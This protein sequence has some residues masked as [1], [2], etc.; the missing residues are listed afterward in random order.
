MTSQTVY[1]GV[2]DDVVSA[3][4]Q[5]LTLKAQGAAAL[6]L[7][8][9]TSGT[10]TINLRN[11]S[12]STVG[13]LEPQSNL[14]MTHTVAAAGSFM[15]LQG[16]GGWVRIGAKT[17]LGG[18]APVLAVS[19]ALTTDLIYFW[20]DGSLSVE[21]AVTSLASGDCDANGEVGRIWKYTKNTNGDINLCACAKQA[22]A[23]AFKALTAGGDCT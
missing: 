22:G 20:G 1:S 2:T 10:S 11:V 16:S 3:S 9:G 15:Q 8:G 19:E 21:T 13:T 23:F 6:E 17:N 12:G 14:T 4:G 18:T 7:Q 5:A